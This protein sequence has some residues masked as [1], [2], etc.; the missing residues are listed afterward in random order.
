MEAR[1]DTAQ[2]KPI[3]WSTWAR[4]GNTYTGPP[5]VQALNS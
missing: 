1:E 4:C 5:G 2:F 3:P